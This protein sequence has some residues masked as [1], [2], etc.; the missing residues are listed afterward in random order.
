[1]IVNEEAEL[2]GTLLSIFG[3]ETKQLAGRF[4]ICFCFDLASVHHELNDSLINIL[5]L[6]PSLFCQVK[7]KYKVITPHR[8]SCP[9]LVF[10]SALIAHVWYDVKHIAEYILC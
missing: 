9:L 6:L 2:A 10:P 4:G 5:T 3:D 7:W 8:V 1:M